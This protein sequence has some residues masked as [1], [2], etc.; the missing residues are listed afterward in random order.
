MEID[1][2][3]GCG[4]TEIRLPNSVHLINSSGDTIFEFRLEL[5]QST[6]KIS[7]IIDYNKIPFE[8]FSR[9]D[10]KNTTIYLS[11]FEST[12]LAVTIENNKIKYS[13]MNSEIDINLI[14]NNLHEKI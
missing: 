1:E 4:Y 7:E 10:A 3:T 2:S 12:Y 6:G 11:K 8:I 14:L 13:I 5:N 9:M